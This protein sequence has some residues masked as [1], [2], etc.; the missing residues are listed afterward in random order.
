MNFSIVI[1]LFFILLSIKKRDTGLMVAAIMQPMINSFLLI[2]T[3]GVNLILNLFFILLYRNEIL[4][5]FKTK[6]P[7]RNIYIIYA[8]LILFSTSIAPIKH[9]FM[10]IQDILS[11]TIIPLCATI[12]FKKQNN[13]N[14]FVKLLFYCLL[15]CIFYV[16]CFEIVQ[17]TNP[18]VE[19]A[20][21]QNL[22]NGTLMTKTRFGVKQIQCLFSYHETA[23]CFF[24]MMAVF[25][26]WI[27]SYYTNLLFSKK[28]IFIIFILSCIC[29]FFTGSRSSI[30]SLFIGLI[31]FIKYSKKYVVLLFSFAIICIVVFPDYFSNLYNSIIDSNNSSTQGSNL[32]LRNN[33][34]EISIY[35]M[36]SSLNGALF[37]NGHGFT[38]DFLIGKVAELAGAESLWFRLMIDEGFL[39]IAFMT[40]IFIYT[41]K[42]SYNINKHMIFTVLA[43][44]FAKSIAVVPSIE[45][46]W[47]FIFVV[48]FKY[49]K[50]SKNQLF[51]SSSRKNPKV[52]SF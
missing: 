32:E 20:I 14:V 39:G 42:L 9:Y 18:I 40:Y 26:M 19:N 25:F 37:G 41:L 52:R 30:I 3:I 17:Q 49:I 27:M 24:W 35:Y 46:S 34:L 31:P 10:S 11:F 2:D 13:L 4:S 15:I 38:D 44:I 50:L 1:L 28:Y 16:L 5:F 45:V 22:F 43:F 21:S 8:L 7:Y 33:Q 12:C 23:G 6:N 48:Y 47:L 36:L 29:C 51:Y